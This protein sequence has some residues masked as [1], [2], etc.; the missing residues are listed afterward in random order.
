[1]DYLVFLANVW[2]IDVFQRV[3]IKVKIDREIFR[4]FFYT[5]ISLVNKLRCK[6]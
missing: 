3:A 4:I 1:M 5:C 2:R 6:I